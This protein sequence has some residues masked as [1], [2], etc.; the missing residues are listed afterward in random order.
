MAM[1]PL[2]LHFGVK[3]AL[4]AFQYLTVEEAKDGQ[5][6]TRE[7]NRNRQIRAA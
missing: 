7:G 4:I 1:V 3:A 6:T 5:C 2:L